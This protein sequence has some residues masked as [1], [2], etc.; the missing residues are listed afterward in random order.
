MDRPQSSRAAALHHHDGGHSIGVICRV[1]DDPDL[2]VRQRDKALMEVEFMDYTQG[3]AIVGLCCHADDVSMW[4]P[5]RLR[6]AGR[7]SRDRFG[8]L[9]EK[10]WPMKRRIAAAGNTVVPAVLA[11]RERGLAVRCE[12]RELQEDETWIA[13]NDYNHFSASDPLSLLGLI[14]MI[15]SRDADWGRRTTKLTNS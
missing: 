2:E 6:H 5:V 1:V 3:V 11:I 8:R 15:E 12:R 7:L 14:A 10:G 9:R 4:I 13:E